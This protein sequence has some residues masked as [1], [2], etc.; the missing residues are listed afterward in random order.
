MHVTTTPGSSPGHGLLVLSSPLANGG[1]SRFSSLSASYPLKLLSPSPLTS[2]PENLGTCYVLAYGGG[3]VAG[4]EISLDIV[5][6]AGA[7]LL[8][9]TQ[10]STKVFR[11]RPG[12]RPLS[13]GP[14]RNPGS[15]KDH[16]KTIQRQHI[17]VEQDGYLL[18][19]PNAVQPYASS[20]YHQAQRVTLQG[21]GSSVVLLDWFTSGRSL[22]VSK[23]STRGIVG[24]GKTKEEWEFERYSS[25][26][27][28]VLDGEVIMRERTVLDNDNGDETIPST[29]TPTA[30]KGT[31]PI[32]TLA[33]RMRPYQTY[34]TMLI[35]GPHFQTL[36]K[37]LQTLSQDPSQTQFQ[38]QRPNGTLLW[39]FS[40]VGKSASR[41]GDAQQGGV[42]RVAGVETEVVGEFIRGVL[43]RGGVERLVGKGLWERIW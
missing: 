27:E 35:Y 4:D 7:G 32:P 1:R 5:V 9:L 38:A 43:E 18:L 17:R 15:G 3:L 20:S 11:V 34:A 26:N 2:T 25:L 16:G 21:H 28:V 39:S 10:G 12:L 19:L 31:I 40:L 22:S 33:D 29:E 36:L 42:L 8:L 30:A 37:A 41:S 24:C 13:L 6:Q 14:Q 23:T